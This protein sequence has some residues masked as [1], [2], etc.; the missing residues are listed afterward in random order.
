MESTHLIYFPYLP[1]A[2]MLLCFLMLISHSS[3]IT[4]C[5]SLAPCL[6]TNFIAITRFLFLLR[7]NRHYCLVE[8]YFN[9]R[10]CCCCCNAFPWLKHIHVV[11]RSKLVHAPAHP[12][13][14]AQLL[15]LDQRCWLCIFVIIWLFQIPIWM[16]GERVYVHY[17]TLCLS[18]LHA[19]SWNVVVWRRWCRI[20]FFILWHCVDATRVRVH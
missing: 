3:I 7:A 11:G 2:L 13:V 18:T 12:V 6:C 14:A 9:K 4:L 10:V 16:D 15:P 17:V 20:V 1:L 8:L 5:K 19:R